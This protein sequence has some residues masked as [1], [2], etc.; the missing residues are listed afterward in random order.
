MRCL[1][2]GLALGSAFFGPVAMAQE[3]PEPVPVE[4]WSLE[5]V[6]NLG[7]EIYRHDIAA[8]VATDAL[9]EHVDGTPPTD[10]RGW[11]VTPNDDGLKVR[12]IRLD[13]EAFRAGWDV[14]V[15][16]GVA[17]PV[18]TPTDDVLSE[19]EQ[20]QF[21]ARQTAFANVGQLRCSTQMNTVVL[22]DPDSDGWL[23]WLLA[24]TTETGAIPLGGHYR[25]RISADG[26]SV[27]MRDQLSVSCLTM[28]DEPNVVGMVTNQIVSDIPVE[29]HVFLSLLNR[30]TLYV[31]AGGLVY[32]V[33]GDSIRPMAV[34]RE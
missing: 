20:A 9:L 18:V 10:L 21:L 23:V 12:F 14:L 30:K 7:R 26:Q 17:G 5:R 19:G 3:P 11:I 29:T 32:A 22:K 31:Y 34:P 2:V 15:R 1:A 8:W 28:Q 33:E 25:F 13:G 6:A 27:L 24:S 16:D 4:A